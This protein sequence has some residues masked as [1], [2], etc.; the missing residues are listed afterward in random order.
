MV[1]EGSN[2]HEV[3]LSTRKTNGSYI[4]EVRDNGCGM[5]YEISRKVFS[6]FF[7]TKGSDMGTGLGLLTTKKIV[8]Q[9]GGKVSFDTEEG[10]GSV[11]RI[12]LPLDNLPEL[13][14]Q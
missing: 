9:H 7:S 10:V 12:E 14:E 5:D 4:Y 2:G 11:F 6:S 1:S 13:D 3:T 8:H